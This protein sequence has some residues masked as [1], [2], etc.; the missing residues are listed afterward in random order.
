MP[1]VILACIWA[2]SVS[3]WSR[4]I[5]GDWGERSYD[6]QTKLPGWLGPRIGL[7]RRRVPSDRAEYV[8]WA[9]QI[10]W[11]GIILMTLATAIILIFGN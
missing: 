4:T 8:R 5:W 3:L 11:L 9:K 6:M 10:S 7:F 1:K 2:I